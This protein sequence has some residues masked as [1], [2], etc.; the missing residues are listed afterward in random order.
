MKDADAPSLWATC[1]W[2]TCGAMPQHPYNSVPSPSLWKDIPATFTREARTDHRRERGLIRAGQGH[3]ERDRRIEGLPRLHLLRYRGPCRHVTSV[4]LEASGLKRGRSASE[5]E[6]PRT[7]G[8]RGVGSADQQSV[9]LTEISRSAVEREGLERDNLK[10]S[11]AQIR[12]DLV[13][14]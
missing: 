13:K 6:W 9:D 8:W 11:F 3:A 2:C 10:V 12:D 1:S 4:R 5:R 14:Q 7:C